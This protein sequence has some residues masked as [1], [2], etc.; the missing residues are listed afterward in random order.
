MSSSDTSVWRALD[1]Q[2]SLARVKGCGPVCDFIELALGFAPD[3]FPQRGVELRETP[4]RLDQPGD[5]MMI[6]RIG[7]VAIATGIPRV[8]NAIA[9]VVGSLSL[10]ELFSPFGEAELQRALGP[11]DGGRL[12]HTFHFTLIN[13]REFRPYQGDV[14]TVRLL[15]ADFA[16][17]REDVDAFAVCEDDEAAA[18]TSIR[19]SVP[20]YV[21]IGV[22]TEE[23]HRRKGLGLAV[24]SATT[25]WILQQ[26]AVAHYNTTPHNTASV[27][28]ARRLG[29]ILTSELI[30]A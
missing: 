17:T 9:P 26:G 14:P 2:Q 8:L 29:F 28:L 6:R 10:W 13:Q 18:L 20:D 16:V 4:V 21:Y 7:N 11:A 1:D 30:S 15:P 12:H 3:S 24:V 25:D 22:E 27:R 19:S 5:R 23:G